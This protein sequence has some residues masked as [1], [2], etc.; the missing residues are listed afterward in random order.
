MSLEGVVLAAM[1]TVRAFALPAGFTVEP[2][3]AVPQISMSTNGRLAAVITAADNALRHRV[4]RWD[5]AGEFSIFAPLYVLTQPGA[6]SGPHETPDPQFPAESSAVVFAGDALLVTAGTFWSGAYS[7]TSYEV[8]R[9]GRYS[10]ARWPLPSCASNG[11][12]VDQHAFGAD[13]DGRVAI[14]IDRTGSGSF[15]VMRDDPSIFAPAAFIVRNGACRTLGRGIVNGVNGLWAVGY[16]GYLNGKLAPD[17]LNATMQKDVAARWY[18][19][20]LRELG[21]GDALAVNSSG[22]TVG[23]DAVPVPVLCATQQSFC[24]AVPHAV[25]WDVTGRRLALAPHSPNSVA[26]AV[27]NDGTVVGM[28]TDRKGRH[29]AFRWRHGVLQRLDDLP[30]P[31][32]WRFES[33]YAIGDDGSIAGIGTHDGIATVFVYR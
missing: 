24:P 23:A 22:L 2:E 32:G 20:H 16:R 10:A 30:H 26:Y 12:S 11:D 25:A 29:F 4:I 28:L 5:A 7:G 1:M 17:N 8:Q 31:P 9:W 6:A 13:A 15:Q 3:A 18:G 33:A 14:T 19:T 21:S 27:S